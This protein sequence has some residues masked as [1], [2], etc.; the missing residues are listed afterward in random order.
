MW[1]LLFITVAF[2]IIKLNNAV[3]PFEIHSSDSVKSADLSSAYCSG[4]Y[5]LNLSITI[6]SFTGDNTCFPNDISL[7][8]EFYDNANN[9]EIIACSIT[10]TETITSSISYTIVNGTYIERAETAIFP[11][12]Y[13]ECE[14]NYL[15]S[16]LNSGIDTLYYKWNKAE[17]ADLGSCIDLNIADLAISGEFSLNC[18]VETDIVCESNQVWS[19]CAGT[20]LT[21]DDYIAGNVGLTIC[22]EKCA[23]PEDYPYWDGDACVAAENCATMAPTRVPTYAP[24]VKPT[25]KTK[26]PTTRPTSA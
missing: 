14:E 12:V 6:I 13:G 7:E 17:M 23:C 26:Q 2:M 5:Y 1:S 11:G 24:T 15:L 20:L 16:K 4:S 10:S 18:A 9:S 25:K 8:I 22:E 19:D 21:C 3:G